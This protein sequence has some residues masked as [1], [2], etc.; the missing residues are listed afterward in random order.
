MLIDQYGNPIKGQG[1]H[2]KSFDSMGRILIHD[3][4]TGLTVYAGNVFEAKTV[5]GGKNLIV[6][7]RVMNG[8]MIYMHGDRA[9]KV[10]VREFLD[11]IMSGDL[12]PKSIKEIDPERLSFA[13]I[14]LDSLANRRTAEQTIDYYGDGAV[15][16]YL[17]SDG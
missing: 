15:D 1:I 14:G 13:A 6:A 16:R 7:M 17:S 3:E 10:P 8:Y 5:K 2:A 12:E 9:K 11:R 4:E